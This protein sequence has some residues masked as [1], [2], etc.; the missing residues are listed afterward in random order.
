MKKAETTH[1]EKYIN[2]CR[3]AAWKY[4]KRRR[5]EYEELEGQAF[6]IYAEALNRWNPGTATFSTFLTFRLKKLEDYCD[7]LERR[8]IGSRSIAIKES[9]KR[10]ASVKTLFVV[11]YKNSIAK[12]QVFPG[13]DDIIRDVETSISKEAAKVMTWILFREWHYTPSIEA[14]QRVFKKQWPPVKTREIW[15]KLKNY[16]QSGEMY[17]II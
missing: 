10:V 13:R 3:K 14:A 5:V 4:A 8:S 17:A 16:C 7:Y 2:M 6:L 9:R 12:S 1:F 15:Q 11:P